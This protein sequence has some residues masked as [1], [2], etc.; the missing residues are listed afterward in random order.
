MN[1]VLRY[2]VCALLASGKGGAL[3]TDALAQR[4]VTATVDSADFG[5]GARYGNGLATID[6]DGRKAL[7]HTGG[8]IS[9]SSSMMFDAVADGGVFASANIGGINYRP[10]EIT[11]YGIR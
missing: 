6:I 5:A 2:T 10:R 8:M 11:R 9:F 4:F 1:V 3:M 7:H